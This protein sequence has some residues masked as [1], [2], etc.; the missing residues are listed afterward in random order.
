MTT[1]RLKPE[2]RLRAAARA[3]ALANEG[4]DIPEILELLNA[5]GFR[6]GNGA[7]LTDRLV[8]GYLYAWKKTGQPL[9]EL[10]RDRKGQICFTK[11]YRHHERPSRKVRPVEELPTIDSSTIQGRTASELAL[12]LIFGSFLAA[13]AAVVGIGLLINHLGGI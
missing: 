4:W 5:E 8:Y 7:P 1:I 3:A 2:D 12:G 13:A 10:I 9:R 11:T 6:Q